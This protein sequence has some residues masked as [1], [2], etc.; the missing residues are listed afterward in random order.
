[1]QGLGGAWTAR[2]PPAQAEA[3]ARQEQS[4]GRAGGPRATE[5]VRHRVQKPES[6]LQ[7]D[8]GVGGAHGGSG[9]DSPVL[10]MP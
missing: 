3:T 9:P 8:I 10:Q 6:G 4:T 7:G 2:G 5:S 1:M